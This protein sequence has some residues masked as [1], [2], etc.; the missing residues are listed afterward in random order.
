MHSMRS[1]LL[2]M[3]KTRE[4]GVTQVV[5]GLPEDVGRGLKHSEPHLVQRMEIMNDN[6]CNRQAEQDKIRTDTGTAMQVSFDTCIT[7]YNNQYKIVLLARYNIKN[8][9]TKRKYCSVIRKS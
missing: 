9:T 1:K 7:L 6:S 8:T 2:K 4:R 3:S 5:P